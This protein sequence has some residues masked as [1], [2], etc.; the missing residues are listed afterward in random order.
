MRSAAYDT[1]DA[2][3]L[4][5]AEH[6]VSRVLAEATDLAGSYPDILSAVAATLGW[7]VAAAWELDPVEP[8]TLRRAAFW[9]D[10][11]IPDASL[12]ELRVRV[13]MPVGHGL[14]GRVWTSAQ[15]TWMVDGT[16]APASPRAHAPR[17][18]G[19]H[20]AFCFPILADD[21]IAGVMEFFT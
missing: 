20:S 6:A 16:A 11:S 15:P 12:A 17:A 10:A 9:P 8:G 5:R 18:A 2:V 3:T 21:G 4:L 13:D 1:G 7:D 19:L 14:P